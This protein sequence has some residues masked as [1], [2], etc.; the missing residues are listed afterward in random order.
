MDPP[1]RS[2]RKAMKYGESLRLCPWGRNCA[3]HKH[4]GKCRCRDTQAYP[5]D[6]SLWS[7]CN[8]SPLRTENWGQRYIKSHQ[9]SGHKFPPVANAARGGPSRTA[10]HP[11][12]VVLRSRICPHFY[13]RARP[14]LA[15]SIHANQITRRRIFDWAGLGTE[16][17]SV[18]LLSRGERG[19][20]G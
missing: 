18:G 9:F 1:I 11:H 10:S 16:A 17:G 6:P 14:I 13:P 4:N 7:R 8:R 5:R 12:A 15:Y 3:Q 2:A 20:F 19:E